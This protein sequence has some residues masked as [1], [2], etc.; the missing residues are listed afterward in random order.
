MR[1]NKKQPLPTY[2]RPRLAGGLQ[3]C[4]ASLASRL[5][6]LLSNPPL[7]SR[8]PRPRPNQAAPQYHGQVKQETQNH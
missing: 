8:P 6:P 1:T 7:F 4:L 5:P 2:L 3:Q